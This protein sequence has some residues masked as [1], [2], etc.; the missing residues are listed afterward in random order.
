MSANLRGVNSRGMLR[1][2]A[3]L[4]MLDRATSIR[5]RDPGRVG[6]GGVLV[7]GGRAFSPVVTTFTMRRAIN[8]PRGAGIGWVNIR[9]TTHQGAIASTP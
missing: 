2:P 5:I 9:N 3:Y 1:M 8:K 6:R 7:D 4:G